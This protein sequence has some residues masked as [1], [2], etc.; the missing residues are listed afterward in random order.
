MRKRFSQ[1]LRFD[2][3]TAEFELLETER[4]RPRTIT[5]AWPEK[6]YARPPREEGEASAS[7]AE[8]EARLKSEFRADINPDIL[9]RRFYIGGDI[10]CLVVCIN[11]MASGEQVSH[12]I[13]RQGMRP[14]CM[15]GAPDGEG[16]GQYAIDHVFAMQE[17]ELNPLWKDIKSAISEGRTAVFLDGDKNAVLLDTRGFASRGVESAQNEKVIRGPQE[18]FNENLRTNVTLLR[19]II[20]TEDFVCEFRDSGGKNN[21]KVVVAYREGVANRALVEEVRRRLSAVDTDMIISDGILEQL[22]D[23]RR[24]SPIPQVL[25]T[26][27]PDRVAAQIMG[28]HVAVLLEGSPYANVMPATIFTLMSSSEDSYLR[29]PLGSILRV[30]RYIGA[31]LSILLPGYFLALTLHHPGMMSTES[32][33][34]VIQSRQMVFLPLG[35]E[36][37]FLLWV[38]QLLR[39]AGLRVPGSI[40]QS[41][42]IIGGLILGQA[43]VTANMVSTLVLIVVALTGLGSFTIPDYSSQLA[44]G[45][46]RLVL[47]LLAWVGGLLGLCSGVLLITAWMAS[48][49][50]YGVPFFAPVAPKTY[51]RRPAFLRGM[52]T[53]H[54]NPED[55]LN[56]RQEGESSS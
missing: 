33:A 20:K 9:F 30:V 2:E 49:K 15:D 42:G 26:E 37:L 7:V 35:A 38:F 39:E 34:T 41:I 4:G 21:V 36:M 45:Y 32:L 12:F 46:F 55:Y 56:T 27:R 44:A 13:L 5:G 19:R 50:S 16:R 10:L 31:A 28:G 23:P 54:Q 48:L 22:T 29:Q 11:G 51:S 8:N 24:R 18:G 53:M 52:I 1:A 3:G 47:V 14:G 43:A 25:A 40:G 6:E 17:A